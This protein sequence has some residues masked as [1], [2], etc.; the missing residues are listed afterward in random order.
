M[1]NRLVGNKSSYLVFWPVI[2][3]LGAAAIAGFLFKLQVLAFAAVVLFLLALVCRLWIIQAGKN[4]EFRMTGESTGLYPGQKSDFIFHIKNNKLVPVLWADL[5]YPLGKD[6]CITP[7]ET[8]PAMEWEKLLLREDG[9]SEEI[10]GESHLSSFSWYEAKTVTVRWTARHRGIYSNK[11]WSLRT[12]DGFGLGQTEQKLSMGYLRDMAVFPDRIPVNSDYFVKNAWNSDTGTHGVLEDQT[13]IRSV[14]EYQ[15]GDNV[16]HINWRLAARGL[17]L[18]VNLYEEILPQNTFFIFDG[19]SFSGPESHRE[20]MEEALCV[21]GSAAA[22]LG[23]RNIRCALSMSEGAYSQ[24]YQNVQD[25]ADPR[26]LLWAL[27]AY[28]PA[29]AVKDDSNK[30][31]R[32]KSRFDPSFIGEEAHKASRCYYFVYNPDLCDQSLISLIGEEK[33]TVLSYLPG[34]PSLRYRTREV[35][36]L[37]LK[38]GK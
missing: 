28:Q 11:G 14:R 15:P 7:E 1:K 17:P 16:K 38:G 29:E 5:F 33:V 24:V 6:L 34:R 13:V 32:Q 20:E 30:I 35:R 18:S 31:I 3:F 23:E 37:I 2:A 10:V 4:M 26:Q 22:S 27:A 21:I 8:R 36:S 9:A 25:N 19:E 12:G